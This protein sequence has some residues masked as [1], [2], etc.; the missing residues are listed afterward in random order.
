MAKILISWIAVQNDF[1]NG[2]MPVNKKGPSST[3][4][5]L[6]WKKDN[7]E[8][9]YHLLLSDKKS[10]NEDDK[11]L[12][13][14]T[15]LSRTYKHK[16]EHY[17]LGIDDVINVSEIYGKVNAL[18]VSL[19]E[20]ELDIFVSPGTP[21]MQVAWYLAHETLALKTRL[22]Q[23]RKR[24]DTKTKVDHEW[25][26]IILNRSLIPNTLLF[27]EERKR[28]PQD[29]IPSKQLI[30]KSVKPIYDLAKK[31]AMADSATVLIL[32]E[33]GTGK[34]GLAR[35]IHDHSPRAKG[36]FITVNCAS[37]GESL[38][39]S[40]LFGY[41][42]GSHNTAQKD[43]PGLFE[44]ANH[45][46]IFLDEI[47]DIAPYMQQSLLRVL[48]EREVCRVGES[49][50]RKL[51]IRVITATNQNLPKLCDE[52]KFRWDLY[53]RITVVDLTL[54]S[55]RERGVKEMEELFD[56]LL[57][58]NA[59]DHKR[60]EILVSDSVRKKIFN[61]QFPGN[62]REL[63]N[64]IERLYAMVENEVT[65]MDIPKSFGVTPSTQ[66]LK[67]DD[68]IAEHVKKVYEMCGR[69][70]TRVAGVLGISNNTVKKNLN[71]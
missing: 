20:H 48:Q 68:V 62:I 61:H 43:T 59:K 11:L 4:H 49:K 13:L 58:K 35:Y 12:H 51:N 23:V 34:E 36:P 30:T 46:T 26:E 39:E 24:E 56:F 33:T 1:T 8:Y 16:I 25:V 65:E 31:V 64:F 40:R 5:E 66:S 67:L 63:E 17:A 45:G 41:A 47:G 38:L 28:K 57:A 55:L 21:A 37:I 53:Y 71:L 6:F 52:G 60:P 2:N 22:F 15:H 70:V 9:D 54:P 19:R 44:D 32:G 18:L 29:S 7:Q 69:N 3:V 42:K 10:E 14:S 50:P 27:N